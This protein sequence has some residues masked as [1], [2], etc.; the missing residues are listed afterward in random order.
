MSKR[1]STTAPRSTTTPNARRRSDD[2]DDS[3]EAQLR[4]QDREDFDMEAIDAGHEETA[5][6]RAYGSRLCCNPAPRLLPR[7]R[8]YTTFLQDHRAQSPPG[9]PPPNLVLAPPR[10]STSR[11]KIKMMHAPLFARL[12]RSYPYDFEFRARPDLLPD[13]SWSHSERKR[14]LSSGLATASSPARFTTGSPVTSPAPSRPTPPSLPQRKDVSIQAPTPRIRPIG[15]AFRFLDVSAEDSDEEEEEEEEDEETLSDKGPA[16]RVPRGRGNEDDLRAL[17]AAYEDAGREY[18]RAPEKSTRCSTHSRP[19]R[20]IPADDHP[21]LKAPFR[22]PCPALA[23]GDRGCGTRSPP[24]RDGFIVVLREVPVSGQRVKYARSS[25]TTT[26]STSSRKRRRFDRVRVVSGSSIGNNWACHRQ[27]PRLPHRAA[28]SNSEIVVFQ[29][30][31]RYV[32]R[33]FR[34]GDLVRE[35][36]QAQGRV[37]LIVATFTGDKPKP[38]QTEFPDHVFKVRAADVDF[39]TYDER[40]S[41]LTIEHAGI[42]SSPLRRHACPGS[43]KG[44]HKGFQGTVIGDHDNAARVRRLAKKRRKGE[45]SWRDE[46][47]DGIVVTIR[48]DTGHS[49]VE[50]TVDKCL[51]RQGFAGAENSTSSAY[52]FSAPFKRSALGINSSAALAWRGRRGWMCIPGL[53]GKRFDVQVVGITGVKERTSP[54]LLALEGRHGHILA[55]APIQRGTKKLDVCGVGRTGTKHAVYAQCIKPRR[56]DDD[57]RSLTEISQRV[58]VIGPDMGEGTSFEGCYGLTQPAASSV[59][60][61]SFLWRKPLRRPFSRRPVFAWRR[62]LH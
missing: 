32:N 58:V 4:R 62:M 30:S 19:T 18:S 3:Y 1:T 15:A 41:G 61:S 2:D 7:R 17:A 5:L 59:L 37:G 34:C 11:R 60:K 54:T 57:G 40:E 56:K 6:R 10:P 43:G 36:R 12:A 9:L 33:D 16:P 53:S 23:E 25:K 46:D 38:E 42:S 8:F 45:D 26:A 35:N 55:N 27:Q 21:P 44:M 29:I 52:A 31:I 48:S 13:L 47:Q 51:H 20:R 24:R 14:L 49:T 22:G 50:V 39:A 28:S